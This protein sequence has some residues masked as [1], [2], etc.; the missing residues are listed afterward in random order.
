MLREGKSYPFIAYMYKLFITDLVNILPE[1]SQ[2]LVQAL[3]L[4]LFHHRFLGGC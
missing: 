2:N 3:P 1:T 4:S